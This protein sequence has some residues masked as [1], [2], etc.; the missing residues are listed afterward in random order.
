[1]FRRFQW[2]IQEYKREY[3][4]AVSFLILSDIIGLFPPYITGRLIDGVYADILTLP[5]FLAII[6]L[7]VF[8]VVL[9]YFMAMGWS[10]YVWRASAEI[11]LMARNRLMKKFLRVSQAFFE[12]HSTGSL[13]GRATNDVYSLFEFAGFGTLTLFDSTVFPIMIVI[14]MMVSG[15]W[16]LTVFS[17]LPLPF[18]ALLCRWIGKRIYTRWG[19]VQEAFDRMNAHTL[20]DIEGIRLLRVFNLTQTR[21]ARFQKMGRNLVDRNMDV[22]RYQAIM[23]PIQRF[24]PALTYVIAL[25]YGSVLISRGDLSLGQLVTHTYYL[26]MLVWPMYALG[27]F[28]NSHQQ[29]EASMERID[30]IL[31]EK[32]ELQDSPE[33]IEAP[34]YQNLR[35]CAHSFTYPGD[36]ERTLNGIDLELQRGRSLGVVGKTG[37]G[38]STLLK[39]FVRLYRQNLEDMFWNGRSIGAFTLASIRKQ[40]AYVPQNPMIFSKSVRENI[41]IGKSEVPDT[42][43]AEVIRMADFEKDVLQFEKGWD[44]LC[45][46]KGISL[47]GGQKQRIALCRA[48]LKDAPIV[49]LDDAMSAVDGTTERTI[50]DHLRPLKKGKTFVIVAHRLSQVKELDE[51]IVLDKGRIVE[52]GSHEELMQNNGWYARQYK[53]Q[54]SGRGEDEKK[55]A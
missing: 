30:D 44:T 14:M 5:Q 46:E 24:I 27:N 19:A 51:I 10:Y 18:L 42:R 26:N 6:G 49:L 4:L 7:D 15:D 52:R 29:A 55:E 33:A 48:L 9:K 2:F 53:Q 11:E 39:Q 23:S 21:R 8:V 12:K 22:V 13:M 1:M 32:E 35:L 34:S 45:G 40:I 38:K 20:E 28:I 50:M 37:T 41:T 3:I 47:S 25:S 31:E 43:I 17:V 54:M 16:R 36:K